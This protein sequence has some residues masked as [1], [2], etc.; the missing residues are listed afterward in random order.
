MIIIIVLFF[1]LLFRYYIQTENFKIVS[2]KWFHYILR[3]LKSDNVVSLFDDI[4]RYRHLFVLQIL[5]HVYAYYYG[6]C[7]L[8]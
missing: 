2:L 5:V 7:V 3:L 1:L 4:D 8:L 6:F